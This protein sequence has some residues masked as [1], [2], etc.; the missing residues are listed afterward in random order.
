MLFFILVSSSCLSF[1]FVLLIF[2]IHLRVTSLLLVASPAEA[3]I[4]TTLSVLRGFRSLER[5][6]YIPHLP[7]RAVFVP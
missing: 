4:H 2:R 3:Q 1:L 5:H 6:K 7:L